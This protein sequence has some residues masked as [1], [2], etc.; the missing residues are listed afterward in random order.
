[1]ALR[2]LAAVV[3]LMED[4]DKLPQLA[5]T[6]EK[7][8]RVAWKTSPT[9]NSTLLPSPPPTP[10]HSTSLTLSIIEGS[11]NW[12][13]PTVAEW[14]LEVDNLRQLMFDPWTERLESLCLV[15]F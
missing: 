7:T 11:C 4:R 12:F 6:L 13:L 9:A 15:R 1:M 5:T 2:S 10:G 8:L 14:C 3:V